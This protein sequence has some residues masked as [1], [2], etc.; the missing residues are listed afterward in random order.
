MSYVFMIC[1]IAMA[2]AVLCGDF[3]PDR[4][5]LVVRSQ[6]DER[7]DAL[8]HLPGRGGDTEILKAKQIKGYSYFFLKKNG[9]RSQQK[10]FLL[11]GKWIWKCWKY[12]INLLIFFWILGNTCFFAPTESSTS[13]I[14]F[15]PKSVAHCFCLFPAHFTRTLLVWF[16]TSMPIWAG[17][18]WT[19][20]CRRKPI[21]RT[22]PTGWQHSET[23]GKWSVGWEWI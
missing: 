3:Q 2:S 23:A 1:F 12:N 19:C 17:N 20:R 18:I 10:D 8:Q 5:A 7:A 4:H 16:A 22:T 11:M 13:H 15:V 6:H 14:F 21:A 9:I